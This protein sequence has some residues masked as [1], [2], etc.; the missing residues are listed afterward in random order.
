MSEGLFC[1]C[2]I[3]L[4]WHAESLAPHLRQYR[5]QEA[6][7]LLAALNQIEATHELESSGAE[8]RRLDRIEAKLDLTL[9]LLARTLETSA[10]PTPRIV[11]LAPSGAH[12]QDSAPP[13]QGTPLTLELRPSEA[14]PLSL[15]LPAIALEPL[16]GNARVSFEGLTETLDEALY[17][18]VFRRHRQA[19]R[20]R[21][22]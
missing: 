13:A 12:W 19:I 1:E 18:F 7:L 9:H 5:M 4:V 14:L 11:H 6:A 10:T 21:T 22:T 15:K 20:A 16:S 2:T 3:P 8:N 17:Q